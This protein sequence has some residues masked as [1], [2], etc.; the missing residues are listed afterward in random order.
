[1]SKESIAEGTYRT[2]EDIDAN[3]GERRGREARPQLLLELLDADLHRGPAGLRAL[4]LGRA[5]RQ[6]RSGGFIACSLQREHAAAR[7]VEE[8][9]RALEVVLLFQ[10]GSGRGQRLGGARR[11][12]RYAAGEALP[13]RD[14]QVVQEGALDDGR[15]DEVIT[16]ARHRARTCSRSPREFRR[17]RSVQ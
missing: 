12:L 14:A 1:M 10:D 6:L 11:I 16:W 17:R 15:A 13:V 9:E 4:L 5:A 3:R 2:S 7:R 8:G